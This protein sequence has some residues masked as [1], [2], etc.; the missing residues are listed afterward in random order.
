MKLYLQNGTYYEKQADV[1]K[2]KFETVE[3]P[4]SASPKAD[5]VAWMNE[6]Q[7]ASYNGMAIAEVAELDTDLR[8]TAL[9]QAAP[10]QPPA[11]APRHHAASVVAWV[12]DEADN[13]AVEQVFA[14]LGARF[15]EAVR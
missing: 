4:F 8:V 3:F 13:A 10:Q 5:F 14:A 15:H 6:R 1:P 9:P 2:G 11:E 12:L 7:P